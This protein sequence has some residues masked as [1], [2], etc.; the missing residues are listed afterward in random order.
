MSIRW[1][2]KQTIYSYNG[3]PLNNKKE[4]TTD[5]QCNVDIKIIMD[6]KIFW[7]KEAIQVYTLYD[8]I[9]I[10]IILENAN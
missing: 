4:W 9:Y 10:N 8:Y 5:I 1:M 6:L 2:D 3:I 7:V